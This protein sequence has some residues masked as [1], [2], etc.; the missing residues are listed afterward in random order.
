MNFI[1]SPTEQASQLAI[2]YSI[3]HHDTPRSTPPPRV[4]PLPVMPAPASSIASLQAKIWSGSLALEIR[5]AASDCRTYDDSETYLIQYPRLSYLAFILPKL[6]AFFASSLINPETKPTDAWLS[7]E[8][9]PLKWHY[10]LGVLYDLF[11]G[12]EPINLERQIEEVGSSQ[13]GVEGKVADNGTIPWRLTI[14]FTDFPGEHL[15]PLD[16]EGRMML[17]SY[18]NAV[19]EADFIRNGTARTVMMM[20]KEDSDKLW[21]AVQR[22]MNS[23]LNIITMLWP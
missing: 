11:S 21:Q 5:L 14:H 23:R 2:R 3:V 16:S 15:I 1:A 17:D 6:H 18:I 20:S 13:A 19:K 22:R 12:A 10:P 7:F 4:I 8:E 9:V